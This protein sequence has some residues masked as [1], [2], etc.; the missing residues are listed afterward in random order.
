[1]KLSDFVTPL[2]VFYQPE[3]FFPAMK[4]LAYNILVGPNVENESA[5]AKNNPAELL[6][7]QQQWI[8]KGAAAGFGLIVKTPWLFKLNANVVGF[9]YSVDEPNIKFAPGPSDGIKRIYTGLDL[10]PEFD[11]LRALDPSKPIL[12]TLAGG[13]V[14]SQVKVGNRDYDAQVAYYKGFAAVSDIWAFD[15]YSLNRDATRYKT[16]WSADVVK[17]LRGL[18]SNPVW[19]WYETNDQKLKDSVNGRAPTP[20][21]IIETI[22]LSQQAGAS[23][24]GGFFTS[25]TGAFGW[26]GSFFPQV[27]RNGVSVVPQYDAIRSFNKINASTII[28]PPLGEGPIVVDP[29]PKP[30]PAPSLEDRV[31]LLEAMVKAL[32][33]WKNMILGK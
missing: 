17:I 22:T 25:D 29:N 10:K 7:L 31:A 14:T 20:A 19:L 23:G 16:S 12:L 6:R 26:P 2:P 24:F 4:D 13:Q 28:T 33:D 21:E 30:L 5:L 27:D 15:V 18:S 3:R 8:D 32:W 9:T 1:M 11:K